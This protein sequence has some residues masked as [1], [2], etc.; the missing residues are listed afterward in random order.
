M[1]KNVYF[2]KVSSL[3]AILFACVLPMV[4]SYGSMNSFK[5]KTEKY[6]NKD[7]Y[8][9]LY[10]KGMYIGANLGLELSK[11]EIKSALTVSIPGGTNVIVSSDPNINSPSFV[12]KIFIGYSMLFKHRYYLGFEGRA[13]YENIKGT[14]NITYREQNSDFLLQRI[15]KAS[16]NYNF[17]ILVKPGVLVVSNTL[18]YADIGATIAKLLFQK[19]ARYSQNLGAVV[20]ANTSTQQNK[21]NFGLLIGLGLERYLTKSLSANLEYN[22]I[23]FG[24]IINNNSVS[25]GIS[26]AVAGSILTAKTNHVNVQ[27]NTFTIGL[28]Y[29]FLC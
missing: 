5:M 1:E 15:E 16:L 7:T 18:I 6:T 11:I 3:I 13:G 23:Y 24:N 21:Y 9:S 8:A 25:T 27:M 10:F 14:N 28:T 22:F 26:G 2:F 12:G 29:H 19:N 20:S 4:K 17:S